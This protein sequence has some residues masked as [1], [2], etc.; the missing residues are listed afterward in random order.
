MDDSWDTE[1]ESSS[2]G[3]GRVGD[4]VLLGKNFR[5]FIILSGIVKDITFAFYAPSQG[6]TAKKLQELHARLISWGI[7]QPLELQFGSRSRVPCSLWLQYAIPHPLF[8]T[9]FS[10]SYL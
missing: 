7:E 4:S 3:A 1:G 10:C 6:F 8:F 2:S 9:F 5:Q